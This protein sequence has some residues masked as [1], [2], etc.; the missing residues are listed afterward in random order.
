M[1]GVR[2]AFGCQEQ[3]SGVGVLK[4]ELPKPE[5]L[6]PVPTDWNSNQ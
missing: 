6:S 2:E 3:G 5:V 1:L 4:A